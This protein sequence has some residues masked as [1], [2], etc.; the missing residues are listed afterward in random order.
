MKRPSL[1][2]PCLAHHYYASPGE[3]IAEFTFPD[4]T[5]GLISLRT[6]EG[7]PLIEIYRVNGRVRVI[8]S[9]GNSRFDMIADEGGDR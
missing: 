1:K 2:S 8:G 7:Q 3:R 4:G 9:N 6:H 5:G